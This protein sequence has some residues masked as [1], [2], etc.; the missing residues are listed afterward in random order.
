M[1]VG[2]NSLNGKTM[3]S[4]YEDI[5]KWC[6]YPMYDIWKSECENQWN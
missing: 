3:F 4:Q 5:L 1:Y 6:S 2:G